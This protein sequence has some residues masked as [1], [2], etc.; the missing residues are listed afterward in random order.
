MTLTFFFPT[1]NEHTHIREFKIIIRN[2]SDKGWSVDLGGVRIVCRQNDGD[3][4]V[5]T[6]GIRGDRVGVRDIGERTI[7]YHHTTFY[8]QLKSKVVVYYEEIKRE[9][10]RKRI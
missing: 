10:Y 9:I 1:E 6:D 3:C 8:T 2:E 7:H 4:V 5:R